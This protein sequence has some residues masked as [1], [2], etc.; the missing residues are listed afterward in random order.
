MRGDEYVCREDIWIGKLEQLAKQSGGLGM[1]LSRKENRGVTETQRVD[2]NS[3]TNAFFQKEATATSSTK[4]QT[5]IDLKLTTCDCD[6]PWCLGL[7]TPTSP[8]LAAP[9]LRWEGIAR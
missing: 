1:P 3:F 5:S 8:L 9:S 4:A 2:H 7:P 6:F